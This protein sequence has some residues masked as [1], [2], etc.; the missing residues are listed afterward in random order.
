MWNNSQEKKK[1]DVLSDWCS[2]SSRLWRHICRLF[3]SPLE[4]M[5]PKSISHVSVC[6]CVCVCGCGCGWVGRSLCCP[7]GAHTVRQ[8]TS[9]WLQR[10]TRTLLYNRQNNR[11]TGQEGLVPGVSSCKSVSES[12]KRASDEFSQNF[13][14]WQRQNCDSFTE[15]NTIFQML[16]CT[17]TFKN[18]VHFWA[19]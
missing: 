15:N 7:Q 14:H 4:E 16:A 3:I 18:F 5:I 11:T 12:Q 8:L 1:M 6:V 17:A 9:R 19:K 10:G 13:L 2:L